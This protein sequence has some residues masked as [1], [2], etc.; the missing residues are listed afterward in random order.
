[1]ASRYKLQPNELIAPTTTAVT[2][3]VP[4]PIGM[5]S[6]KATLMATGLEGAEAI[7]VSFSVDNGVSFFPASE[8]GTAIELTA[9]TNTVA[10]N[11]PIFIGVTKPA[12]SGAVG[13]Y[14]MTNQQAAQK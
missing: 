13:V 3:E 14:I 2:T 9:T 11:S 1:M 6:L 7:P 5:S 8:F 4:F 12:T 10:I